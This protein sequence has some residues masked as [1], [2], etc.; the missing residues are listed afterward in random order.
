M[1][2]IRRG[3]GSASWLIRTPQPGSYRLSTQAGQA[4]LFRLQVTAG[5]NFGG[6]CAQLWWPPAGSRVA[7][8]PRWGNLRAARPGLGQ[9]SWRTV[10]RAG[11]PGLDDCR[12]RRT[13]RDLCRQRRR[14]PGRP[15]RSPLL[16]ARHIGLD[17]HRLWAHQ[18]CPLGTL[19]RTAGLLPRPALARVGRGNSSLRDDQGITV[20]PP[21]ATAEGQDI[22]AANRAP[23]PFTE[24]LALNQDLARQLDLLPD[25]QSFHVEFKED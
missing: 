16:G 17:T 1:S 23:V 14:P 20:Y 12:L 13:R 4:V 8:H 15:R 10:S 22:A 6:T 24:L 9:R 2:A 19:W 11:T 21:L 5:F 25:G 18:L 7:A 3:I